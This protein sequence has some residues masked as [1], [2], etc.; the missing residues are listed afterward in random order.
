DNAAA[1]RYT[2]SRLTTVAG[3]LLQGIDEDSVDFRP[4]YDGSNQEPVVPPAD[5]RET[6]G[7]SN[8]EPVTVPANYPNLLA[9]GSSGIAVGMATSVPPHNAE[10]LCNALLHLIKHPNAHIEKLVEFVPGPDFPTGGVIIEPRE[11][12]LDA[13]KSGRGGFSLR[14]RG[15]KEEGRLGTS[16]IVVT[17]VPYQVQKAKLVE[18]I[19]ELLNDKKL[20]LLGD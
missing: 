16:Q 13:Y 8:Q 11:S 5:F 15:Q 1:M 4:T 7:D 2:E 17:E 3:L 14:R 19:A 18:R 6:R 10:E 9:N 20:P 12:I